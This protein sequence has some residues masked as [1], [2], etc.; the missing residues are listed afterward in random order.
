[1][2]FFARLLPM[3]VLGFSTGSAFS[4]TVSIENAGLR[5]SADDKGAVEILD[6]RS[7][8]VWKEAR[9]LTSGDSGTTPTLAD[10]AMMPR[11][12]SVSQQGDVIV[13]EAQWEIPLKFEWS[14]RDEREAVVKIS[15]PQPEMILPV[16][17]SGGAAMAYPPPFHSPA[18]S[19]AVVPE[20]EGI[21]YE[22]AETA[23]EADEKRWQRKQLRNLSMPWWGV[24]DLKA[25]MMTM[26]DTPFHAFE[27]AVLCDTDD[28]QRALPSV[29]WTG[30]RGT[31]GSERQITFRV[32][33]EGGYVAM[34]RRFREEMKRQGLFRTF[35]EK[36]QIVPQIRKLKGAMDLWIFAFDRPVTAE[37]VKRIK[38]FGFDKLLLQAISSGMKDGDV[39]RGFTKDAVEQA[40]EYDYVLGYY[41]L[42]SWIYKPKDGDF[43]DEIK[44]ILIKDAKGI[45]TAGHQVWGLHGLWCP[46][47]L[48][49]TLTKVAS[50]EKEGGLSTFF[51]DCTIAGDSLRDCYDPQHPL[52]MDESAAALRGT[53]EQVMQSGMLPGSERGFWY[54]AKSTA[55]FEGIET[56]ITYHSPFQGPTPK[57][58]HGGPMQNQRPNY[59][60]WFVEKNYGA[61]NRVPLFQLVFHDSVYC[62]RRWDD[63]HSRQPELWRMNDLM[64]ICYGVAPIITFHHQIGPFI[65][66]DT[67]DPFIER[68][69]RTYKEVCG[70]HE[71]VGFEEMTNHEFLTEDRKVQRTTFANGKSVVVNFGDKAV[72]VDGETI[73]GMSYRTAGN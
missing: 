50:A 15:S 39:Y 44:K 52:T 17:E 11:I 65:L 20:D 36:A 41:H 33:E 42:F 26:L 40:N 61:H 46:A 45:Y 21:L 34:C 49:E 12:E 31:W 4:S 43:S 9:P 59:Q 67:V 10:A 2:H 63:H 73:E 3:F 16:S 6:K 35:E 55:F 1:M 58:T 71:Q 47:V 29:Q 51:T 14:L 23:Y 37:D 38:G 72:E 32:V 18:A 64:A 56:I 13:M 7:G 70:W 5:L 60:K 8:I 28:G 57:E 66:N 53:V 48:G 54:A 30:Q 68:Y 69:Q 62:T 27:K 19:F 24:T 25:G 22:T